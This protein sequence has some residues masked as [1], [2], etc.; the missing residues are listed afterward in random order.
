MGAKR[1]TGADE[2]PNGLLLQQFLFLEGG[3]PKL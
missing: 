3:K 2:I 1:K